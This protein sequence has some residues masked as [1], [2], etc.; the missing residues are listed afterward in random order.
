M[1]KTV[2]WILIVLGVLIVVLIVGKL[3][4]G[5]GDN[6]VKVSTEKAAKR[7]I[8]ETVNASGKVYPEVEVKI[9]PDISGQITDLFVKEGDSVKKGQ[10]LARIYADIYATQRD[11]AAAAVNQQQA[12]TANS[13]AQL[14]ALKATMDQ[15]QRTYDRQK[16]LLE[17]K[18][19]SKAEFEQ[20]ESAYLSAKANYT[21]TLQAIRGNKASVVSAQASLERANKDLGRT[22]LTAP[23]NGVISSLSVKKGE[24][25]AGNSFNIGTEM[26]RVADMSVMEVRVDVGENDI[27]KVNIGDSA[28]VEVDA[29]NNRKF[30]GVVREVA[31]STTSGASA[32]GSSSSNDVTNYEVRIR[33]DSASYRDLIDPKNPRK[34]IFRPGMNASADIKTKRHEFVLAVPINAVAARVKGSDKSIEDKKKEDK[35]NKPK[36][37]QGD[38]ADNNATVNSDDLEEVVF[39]LQKDGKVKKTIVK[40]GIQ[41]INY[42]EIT[43]G[44][45]A[46]D[47]LVT[48]PYNAV[49]KT[50]KDGNKV[51]VVPKDKLFEK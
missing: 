2:K 47:E 44:L 36:D 8:I 12:V 51:K 7:T 15:A 22:T 24:R 25:V 14:D 16:Q 30:K 50:L 28:D 3:M 29:Y 37:D 34:F 20:A 27:V 49:S 23:M 1:N 6:G 33:L 43:S 19:I 9:S 40:T 46:G 13:Q 48:G 41:D 5:S 35:K 32:L 11:Q 10:V 21:A 39:V 26:M 42:I 4:A 31:S 38:N 17:D 45:N 18:V